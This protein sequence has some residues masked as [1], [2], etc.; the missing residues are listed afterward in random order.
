MK[1]LIVADVHLMVNESGAPTRD[2]FEAFLRSID[3][4]ETSEGSFGSNAV[5]KPTKNATE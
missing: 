4:D 2:A 1:T 5:R 3:T